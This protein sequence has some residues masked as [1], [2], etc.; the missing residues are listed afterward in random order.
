MQIEEG[1]SEHP[2]C[3]MQTHEADKLAVCSL[4]Q[5]LVDGCHEP[6]RLCPSQAASAEN[7]AHVK[8]LQCRP[9]AL[10]ALLFDSPS[11]CKP[12]IAVQD[13]SDDQHAMFCCHSA[14]AAKHRILIISMHSPV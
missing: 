4:A 8:R 14:T 10:M 1:N 7:M 13:F 6:C 9:V 5:Q 11:Y 12:Y 3:L 2:M